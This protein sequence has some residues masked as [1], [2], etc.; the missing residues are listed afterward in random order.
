MRVAWIL[1]FILT[2]S[3]TCLAQHLKI[4]PAKPS[5]SDSISF[6]YDPAFFGDDASIQ[7]KVYFSGIG[8]TERDFPKI[9]IIPLT[10]DGRHWRGYIHSVPVQANA[11]VITFIDSLGK[12]DTNKGNGYWTLFYQNKKPLLGSWAGAGDLLYGEWITE[13][14]VFHLGQNLDS[15]HA[16]F[17]RELILHP[18]AKYAYMRQY[19]AS[20]KIGT[21]ETNQALKSELDSLSILPA[22]TESNLQALRWQY[23]RLKDTLN[24]KRCEQEIFT[25]FPNGS[26]TPQA[27]SLPLLIQAGSSHNFQEQARA[28]QEFKKLFLKTYEAEF[29]TFAM[30]HRAA[31]MLVYMVTHF[32]TEGTMELWKKEVSLLTEAGQIAAYQQGSQR[33]LTKNQ[34]KSEVS[35]THIENKF[36]QFSL[37]PDPS[38]TDAQDLAMLAIALWNKTA[39]GPLKQ[40]ESYSM[41]PEEIKQTRNNKL[42]DLTALLG[43]SLL[44]QNKI[45]DAVNVL[46]ES[47]DINN[48]TE[49][50]TNEL[51]I[52]ALVKSGN[53]DLALSE[54]RKIIALGKS[55][56]AL[57]NFYAKV[58]K[59]QSDLT[60]L[61]ENRLKKTK[62]VMRQKLV[63]EKSADFTVR[64]LSGKSISSASLKN[65]IVVI[66]FWASWCPPCIV[67]LQSMDAVVKKFR[68]DPEVIFLSVNEDD[69]RDHAMKIINK[70]SIQ[71]HFAFDEKR[72]MVYAF[73]A[74]GLPTQLILD[75]KG[76]IRFRAGG[77]S[78]FNEHE[79]AV[80][81]EAMISVLKDLK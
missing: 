6:E 21:P 50:S 41:T 23:N 59:K 31:R 79:N 67:E 71:N 15:V 70:Y 56:R 74:N 48:Y 66:T 80:A 58:G 10:K 65:K 28:Y 9:S 55:T 69:S 2:T 33:L 68:N 46:K 26:W 45:P 54:A 38:L 30:N 72:K 64:D 57:D 5:V 29:G 35:Q 27:K 3:A 62:D 22:L 78:S 13:N 34:S 36:Y 8:S 20:F 73:G 12:R 51:Y 1:T 24:A 37:S 32:S 14:C 42:S 75:K 19:L 11:M 81:L 4:T 43:S 76:D 25:R 53:Q 40:N 63:R 16:F 17:Q 18:K 39:D 44:R 61:L 7:C 60:S 47:V 77:L 52:E 49:P